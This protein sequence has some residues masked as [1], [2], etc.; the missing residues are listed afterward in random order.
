MQGA[1]LSKGVY[2]PQ[3]KERL[4]VETWRVLEQACFSLICNGALII[5]DGWTDMTCRL[6]VNIIL[7]S[8]LGTYFLRAIGV[9]GEEKNVL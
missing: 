9:L 4:I 1:K 3:R 5:F 2:Y 8:P 6:F 7:M